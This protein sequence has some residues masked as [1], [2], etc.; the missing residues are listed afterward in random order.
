MATGELSFWDY[1]RAAFHWKTAVPLLGRMPLNKLALAGFAILGFGNP[2][3]WLLGVGL[4]AAYLLMLAGNPRFQNLVGGMRMLEMKESWAERQQDILERLDRKDRERYER[5]VEQCRAIV[6]TEDGSNVG[7]GIAGLKSEGLNQ[8]LGI[9]LKLLTMRSRILETLSKTRSED[10]QADIDQLN[11]KIVSEK[12]DS[13]VRRAL[14][15][16]LEIQQTRLANLNKSLENLKFTE[17]ELERIEKQVSLISEEI[18]V[19]RDPEQ[20]SVTLDGVVKSIQGT[21]RWVAD[22]SA[23]FDSM[24]SSTPPVDVIQAPARKGIKQ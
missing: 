18:A 19:S 20:W 15:G 22:N 24:E 23:L 8:L 6:R 13:P 2:G 16:T 3:F 9:S 5:L 4:E 1:V 21:S 7:E 12:E 11:K 14:Q 17:T 10:L